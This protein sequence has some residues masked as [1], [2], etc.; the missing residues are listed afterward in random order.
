MNKQKARELNDESRRLLSY[1]I[2]YDYTRYGDLSDWALK[3]LIKKVKK[4]EKGRSDMK[5]EILE[6]L[7]EYKQNYKTTQDLIWFVERKLKG[8]KNVRN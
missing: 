3:R 2:E 4:L 7:K 5:K 1:E 6:I 8:L